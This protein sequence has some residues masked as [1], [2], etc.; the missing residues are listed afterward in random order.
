MHRVATHAGCI[1]ALRQPELRQSLYDAAAILMSDVLVNL[2]G[3]RHKARRTVESR[4]FRKDIFLR[5][6][7]EVL[8]R[9]LAETIAPFLAVGR[10]DLVDLGYRIMLN[11][12]V[13]FAGIDRPERSA[14]ETGELLRLLR[15]FSLAPALGQSR[16]EDVAAKQARIATAMSAFDARFLQ[17]SLARRRALLADVAAGRRDRATLPADVLMALVEGATDLGMTEAQFV[18][19]GIFYMLAGAHTTIHSLAHAIN[20]ILAWV[21]GDPRR[22]ERLRS[23]PFLVQRC[24]FESVRLHPSSPVARRRALAV[25]TLADGIRLAAGEDVEIDL[26]AANRDPALFGASPDRFDPD[27]KLA[28][29]VLPYGLSMGHGMHACLG[30]NLAIGV[31]PRPGSDPATHQFG[32]V[33]L[34]VVALLRAGLRPDPEDPPV[35]DDRVT[36]ITFAR[37]PVLFRP[38]EALL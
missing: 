23:D 30:R 37:Y 12:T 15:E 31:E 17:P 25:V 34:I 8:P 3:E 5:Y 28:Q 38:A 9:T 2:H 19:E 18:Q 36:R 24:V 20:E 14:S 11:L 13:D 33:P 29:G 27:R 22:A 1:H 21:D 10:G 6:E 16:P 7:K 32:V 35:R 4:V 26:A